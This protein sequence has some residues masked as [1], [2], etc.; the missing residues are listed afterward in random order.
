MI[1]LIILLN[2]NVKHYVSDSCFFFWT[3]G[4]KPES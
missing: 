3:C 4:N 2:K 1:I